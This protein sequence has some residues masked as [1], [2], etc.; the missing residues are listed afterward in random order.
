[1]RRRPRSPS[2][3]YYQAQLGACCSGCGLSGVGDDI[4]NTL[5]SGGRSFVDA[6]NAKIANLETSL[7]IIMALSGI[8]ALA[9]VATL[10]RR[11]N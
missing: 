9:G 6:V 1:M 2:R 7:K 10:I 5:T 8:A 4:L 3:A 11:Y